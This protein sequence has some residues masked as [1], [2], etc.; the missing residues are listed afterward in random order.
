MKTASKA[1]NTKKIAQF[2]NKI[3]WMINCEA[4]F[5]WDNRRNKGIRSISPLGT[6][7]SMTGEMIGWIMGYAEGIKDWEET[8]HGKMPKVRKAIQR[9]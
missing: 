2:V 7:F 6:G 9:V 1:V 8:N 5:Y 4:E 3:P